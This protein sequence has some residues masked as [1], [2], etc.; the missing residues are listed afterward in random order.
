MSIGD[1]PTLCRNSE[2]PHGHLIDGDKYLL[3]VDA[4]HERQCDE[5]SLSHS[6]LSI[7]LSLD[8]DLG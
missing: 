2:Q 8:T 3:Q 5:I 1:N 7:V 6:F 4:R